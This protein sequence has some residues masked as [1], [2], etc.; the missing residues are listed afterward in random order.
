MATGQKSRKPKTSKN[1]GVRHKKHK[2]DS[3]ALV[4]MG[5]GAFVNIHRTI[6]K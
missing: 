3:T 1:V 2:M 5:K 6:K 4:I